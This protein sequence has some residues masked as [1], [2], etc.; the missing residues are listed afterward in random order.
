MATAEPTLSRGGRPGRHRRYGLNL[1][2]APSDAEKASYSDRDLAVIIRT[3]LASFGALLISQARFVFQNPIF[4]WTFLPFVL[5]TIVY[6]II[7]LM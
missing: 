1:P 5:A 7:S 2:A 6:Y 4:A 3:S